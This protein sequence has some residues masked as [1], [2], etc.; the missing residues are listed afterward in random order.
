MTISPRD[1]KALALLAAMLVIMLVVRFGF[2]ADDSAAP[3]TSAEM[4]STQLRQRVASLRQTAATLPLRDAVAKQAAAD[5]TNRERGLIQAVTFNQAQAELVETARRI[6]GANQIEIRG[7]DFGAPKV[8]G[9]YGLVYATVT[10][11]CHIEQL[12]NFLADLTREPQLIV[13]SEER[14]SSGNAKDKL[15]TVR[16]VLAGLVQK[17]LVPEKKGPG[18]F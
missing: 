1:R 3:A 10:F 13:P 6:G 11:D 9:D 15:V 16:M 2:L 5:V 8:S 12:L 4:T 18:T 14:I 17:K 7:G